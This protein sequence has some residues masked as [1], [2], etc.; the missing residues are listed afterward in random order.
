MAINM[1]FKGMNIFPPGGGGYIFGPKEKFL[2]AMER[3]FWPDRARNRE[4][5]FRK[6]MAKMPKPPTKSDAI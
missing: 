2:F 6:M 4:E 5:D 1:S 3:L